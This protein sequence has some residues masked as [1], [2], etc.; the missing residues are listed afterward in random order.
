MQSIRQLERNLE[1]NSIN[2]FESKMESKRTLERNSKNLMSAQMER[3]TRL[4]TETRFRA[5]L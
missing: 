1:R 3:N 2:F 4:S 5:Q